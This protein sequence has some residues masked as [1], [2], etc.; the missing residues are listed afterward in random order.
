LIHAYFMK[1]SHT[2]LP[3]ARRDHCEGM[4]FGSNAGSFDFPHVEA[5]MLAV[6]IREVD[7]SRRKHLDDR[8]RPEG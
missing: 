7:I 5:A 1:S 2:R 4:P 6:E 3:V 8:G